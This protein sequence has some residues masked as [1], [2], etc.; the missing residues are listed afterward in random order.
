MIRCGRCHTPNQLQANTCCGCRPASPVRNVDIKNDA[1]AWTACGIPNIGVD[2]RQ[3]MELKR[4]SKNRPGRS[5]FYFATSIEIVSAGWVITSSLAP[6]DTPNKT[7]VAIRITF[8]IYL[9][10]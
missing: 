2:T 10:Y 8:L 5:V 1:N 3:K 6:H 7:S 4:S 9:P